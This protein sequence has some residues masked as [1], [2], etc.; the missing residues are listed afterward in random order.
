[1]TG[2]L[3]LILGPTGRNLAAGM[4]GGI[5]YVLDLDATDVNREM[6]DLDPIDDKDWEFIQQQL[7][8]HF[9][10]T[11]SGVA[12]ELLTETGARARLTKVMPRDF[13][14]VLAATAAAEAAGKDVFEAIMEAANG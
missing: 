13:K 5:A 2:G 11:E 8:I 14:R 12:K 10:E 3:V 1:M 6:L 4:S 9:E 7:Q